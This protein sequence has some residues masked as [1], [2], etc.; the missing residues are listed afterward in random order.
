MVKK[1]FNTWLWLSRF[2]SVLNDLK[3]VNLTCSSI[4]TYNKVGDKWLLCIIEKAKSR[5]QPSHASLKDQEAGVTLTVHVC[6]KYFVI[7]YLTLATKL[8]F[9]L[10]ENTQYGKMPLKAFV[11]NIG[12]IVYTLF[13]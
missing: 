2:F 9:V 5:Q 8:E 13:Q 3:N 1:A 4:F 11:G 10:E 7:F 12:T 6:T